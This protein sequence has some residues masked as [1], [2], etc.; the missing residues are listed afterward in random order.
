ALLLASCCR[1]R[2]PARPLRP[3][4]APQ[5]LK[6]LKDAEGLLREGIAAPASGFEWK[7]AEGARGR[8][9]FAWT[10]AK[11]SGTAILVADLVGEEGNSRRVGRIERAFTAGADPV[12]F[13]ED[14]E[15][16]APRASRLRLTTEPAGEIFLSDLRIIAP[17]PTA[18]LLFLIVFDTTRRD[19]VG[20]YGCPDPSTPHLDRIFRGAFRAERAYAPASWTIPSVAALLTGRVPQVQEGQ[21]GA[22]RGVLPGI[23]TLAQDFQR[24]GWSTA[25]FVANPTLRAEN[26]FAAGFTTFFTT[27]YQGSSIPLPGGQTT[28]HVPRWLSA[29][30]GEPLFLWLLLLDPHDPYMPADRPRGTTPFDPG[31]TGPIVGDE[32]HH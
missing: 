29:H 27:P 22:P 3:P 1:P 32:V 21:D 25:A 31:Y 23:P 6:T 5:Q 30:R 14:L 28:R 26:G 18:D 24:A 2:S 7:F 15:L 11:Q 19:A 8:L 10:A 9:R 20:L 12:F 16:S 4:A 17:S 13:D